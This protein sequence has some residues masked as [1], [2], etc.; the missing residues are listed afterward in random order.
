[1]GQ[2][3]RLAAMSV[4]ALC[5]NFI[6]P[7]AF[8]QTTTAQSTNTNND[9]YRWYWGAYWDWTK[10]QFAKLNTFGVGGRVGFK[11]RPSVSIEAD[12]IYDLPNKA[13]QIV[14]SLGVTTVTTASVRLIHGLVGPKIQ[15]SG[16]RV[17]FFVVAKGGILNFGLSGT[18][19]AALDQLGA[20]HDGDTQPVFY[21]AAG[22]EFKIHG[23]WFRGEGGDEIFFDNG[24]NHNLKVTFGPQFRF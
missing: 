19:G 3:K 13:S 15:T 22:I 2:M 9:D 8:A 7:A 11:I 18:N 4:L 21:P 17:R 16:N 5:L 6:T 1:M 14:T 12:V 24:A 23:I 10:L 20:I